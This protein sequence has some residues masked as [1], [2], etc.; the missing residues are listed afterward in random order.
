MPND[1]SSQAYLRS[2]RLAGESTDILKLH[3]IVEE[4]HQQGYDERSE[5]VAE[6]L[7]MT[8]LLSGRSNEAIPLL[9]AA[10]RHYLE[11]DESDSAVHLQG[12][13]GIACAQASRF[14]EARTHFVQAADYHRSIGNHVGAAKSIANIGNT[15]LAQGDTSMALTCYSESVDI[16]ETV[17]NTEQLA[18]VLGNMANVYTML[19]LFPSALERYARSLDLHTKNSD[20]QGVAQVNANLASVFLATGD[21]P[22][23]LEHAMQ[24]RELHDAIDDRLGA[25]RVTGVI[26]TIYR[27]AGDIGRALE[28]FEESRMRHEAIKDV[29]GVA[30]SMG[31]IAA[32]QLSRGEYDQALESFQRALQMFLDAKSYRN[33]TRT[34]CNVAEALL[35]LGRLDESSVLLSEVVTDVAIDPECTILLRT[36]LGRIA[37]G[38]GDYDA[39]LG[40]YTEALLV[41]KEYSFM[42]EQAQLH[43]RL[44]DLA[45]KRNDFASYIEHNTTSLKLIEEVRG[46][47]ATRR[48]A[49]LEAQ[50]VIDAE[51][52]EKEK[53]RDLLYNTL[54]AAIADRVLRGEQVNDSID[55]AAVLFMD[56]VGFTTMSAAMDP[57]DVVA[58]LSKIFSACDAIVTA[59]GLM[60]IKTIGDSY[61][62]AAIEGDVATS[63]ASTALA[64]MQMMSEHFPG[65]RVRIGIHC[66]PVTAGVIGT[67]RLQYDVWGDTVNVASRMESHGEPGR[68]HVSEALAEALAGAPCNNFMITERGTIDVKGKGAMNTYWLRST[69]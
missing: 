66:G 44:R 10:M 37:E 60:K 57:N 26:G 38:R 52:A 32:V 21:H 34:S 39:A 43:E 55:Y 1:A 28:Y 12:R 58:M 15:Y 11:R 30:N 65:I 47:D 51:R 67:E 35:E 33:A 69:T 42:L 45:Q 31:N 16:Y 3:K 6:A 56:M 9:S 18:S 40:E 63:A 36:L 2:I 50:K 61:M 49:M 54:P 14:D 17:G 29:H 48:L 8:H 62:A 41:A 7:G 5:L 22:R 68:I 27:A 4:M 59:N 64:L 53:H 19:G 20:R 24:S 46:Q 25:A 23:A 13:I